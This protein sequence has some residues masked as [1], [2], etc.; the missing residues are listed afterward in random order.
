MGRRSRRVR[1]RTLGPPLTLRRI[2]FFLV[3]MVLVLGC[4]EV[5]ARIW[6]PPPVEGGAAGPVG[7]L[8]QAHPTR[9]W[10]QSPGLLETPGASFEIGADGLREI[11]ETG[12]SLR[13]LTLGDSSILGH[14]LVHGDT[15]HA[16]LGLALSEQGIEADV[17]CGAVA[18][19][20]TEQSLRL[21]EEVGWPLEPDL[22]VVGNLWSDN[23][24][25][26][27]VDREWLAVLDARWLRLHHLLSGSFIWQWLQHLAHP[28]PETDMSEL[29]HVGWVKAPFENGHRRVPV[30][31][32]TQNLDRMLEEAAQR[33]AGAILL[34]PANPERLEKTWGWGW[35]VYFKAMAAVAE[36]RGVPVVDLVGALREGGLS[37]DEAFQDRMHPTGSANGLYA[38]RVAAVLTAAGWPGNRLVPQ[39]VGAFAQVFTDPGSAVIPL[40]TD[41]ATEGVEDQN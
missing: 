11:P 19:Y 41:P 35:D 13:L 28:L 32:Y 10:T 33:G 21:L 9:I 26:R 8:L 1:K 17:F 15:L 4:L 38:E 14:G 39:D 37:R 29:P 23:S 30:N 36:H 22:L 27:F 6:E 16:R 25:E 2:L 24:Y 12:A 20:S 31:E 7:I 40:L 3:R 18:G 34:Q 5:L